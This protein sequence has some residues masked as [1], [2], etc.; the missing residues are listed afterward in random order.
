M[1]EQEFDFKDFLAA[2][3]RRRKV[4][5]T[6]SLALFALGSLAAYFWPPTYQSYATI[7]IQEQDIPTELVRSTVTSY[8]SKRIQ[9]ISQRVMS[10]TKLLEIIDKYELFKDQKARSTTEEILQKMRSN[11]NLDTITASVVDPRSGQPRSA[12]IAFTIK[13]DGEDPKQVQSVVNELTTLYLDE[14]I[15]VRSEKARETV[16]FLQDEADRLSKQIRATEDKLALFKEKH[17]DTLPERTELTRSLLDR[18]DN[19]ISSIDIEIDKVKDRLYFLEGQV[20]DIKP[21]GENINLDPSARLQSLRNTYLSLISRYSGNHPDVVRIKREIAALEIETGEISSAAQQLQQVEA[22]QTELAILKKKYSDEHPDVIRI[23]KQIESIKTSPLPS[24]GLVKKAKENPSNPALITLK[25]QI[26]RTQSELKTLLEQKKYTQEKIPIYEERLSIAPQVELE[27]REL[28]RELNNSIRKYQDIKAKQM[29]A[30]VSQ[31]LEQ[32]RKGERF[33][34]IEPAVFPEEPISPNRPA[35]LF[36]SLFLSLG[37][38]IGYSVIV[39]NMSDVVR[40]SKSLKSAIG[41][42]PLA[43]IPYLENSREIT[44]RK[45]RFVASTLVT[46]SV[47]VLTLILAHFF[48]KPLDVIWYKALRKAD[49]V[50]NT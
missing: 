36:L 40:G 49:V 25:N 33:E 5:L 27:S 7:L 35:I 30:R 34:L 43:E 3:N 31:Q 47:L 32:E 6:I 15:K 46:V 9:T 28:A 21:Y 14:N 39:E 23:R 38:G 2:I 41:V 24:S 12:T 50:I 16:T 45:R 18:A 48:W 26:N 42:G 4:I 19:S 22:L 17:A 10:R 37:I 1:E 11:I 13:Y 44:G 29:E 20:K 8:A